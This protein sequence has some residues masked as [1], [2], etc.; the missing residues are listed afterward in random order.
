MEANTHQETDRT[1]GQ[2]LKQLRERN[3]YSL[4]DVEQTTGISNA[5][6]SLLENDKIKKPSPNN[7]HKLADFYKVDLRVLL[8]LAGILEADAA[9]ARPA[10]EY[11]FS[12]DNLTPDE[13]EELIAYL[14]F[15][16]LRNDNKL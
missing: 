14:K 15:I 9:P 2:Y 6:L 12:K 7:V 10:T 4:R 3:G 11:V 13:E 5:Y 16:R 1:L 8:S